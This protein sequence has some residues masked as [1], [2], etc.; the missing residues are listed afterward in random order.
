MK[1]LKM[2]NLYP[3]PGAPSNPG[4][5]IPNA[6]A[7]SGNQWFAPLETSAGEVVKS[8][9]ALNSQAEAMEAARNAL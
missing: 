1:G 2:P 4:R 9:E 3:V 6:R 7:G 8:S 5:L